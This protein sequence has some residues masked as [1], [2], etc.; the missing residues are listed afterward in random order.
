MSQALKVWRS[1]FLKAQSDRLQWR[2]LLNEGATKTCN[3]LFLMQKRP[4][5]THY[6]YFGR[7]LELF[8]ELLSTCANDGWHNLV[9]P[10]WTSV[11][12]ITDFSAGMPC[13][14]LPQKSLWQL[15]MDVGANAALIRKGPV[16]TRCCFKPNVFCC[17]KK[18]ST[19]VDLNWW[20]FY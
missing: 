13:I 6:N 2:C 15:W 17:F 14:S 11:C 19:F 8:F 1:V 9:L 5:N 18:E 4:P 7:R 16:E 12:S 10:I 3:D 20:C